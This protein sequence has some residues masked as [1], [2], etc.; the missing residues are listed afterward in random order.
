M[1][2]IDI[3]SRHH[4]YEIKLDTYL[5]KED[6]LEITLLEYNKKYGSPRWIYCDSLEEI[7]NLRPCAYCKLPFEQ[8]DKVVPDPCYGYLKGV[9]GAC[10][11]HGDDNRQYI[12]MNSGEQGLNF[13]QYQ[14]LIQ[15]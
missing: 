5:L 9:S 15:T 13:K 2:F 14:K 7:S 12:N 1:K 11:G 6:E 4:G 3:R 8:S 10:C